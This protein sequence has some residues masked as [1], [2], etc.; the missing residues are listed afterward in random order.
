ML[1]S[2]RSGNTAYGWR[3]LQRCG[4]G[5][6]GACQPEISRCEGQQGRDLDCGNEDERCGH[7]DARPNA[8]AVKAAAPMRQ[9]SAIASHPIGRHVSRG[10]R[11]NAAK[12]SSRR[13]MPDRE[14]R[15]IA[16]PARPMAPT[17]AA[18]G[19]A[20]AQSGITP[21][22]PAAA[23]RHAIETLWNAVMATKIPPPAHS[24]PWPDSSPPNKA[25]RTASPRRAG[26]SEFTNEPT[27]KNAADRRRPGRPPQRH[28]ADRHANAENTSE[29]T[30]KTTAPA[31]GTRC[32]PASTLVARSRFRPGR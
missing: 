26:V 12:T 20:S 30:N 3:S 19:S 29:A 1:S 27:P 25:T 13:K 11:P 5:H 18:A 7:G 14:P 17:V 10:D 23:T 16:Q 31:S 28:T 8:V 21:R 9:Q 24:R 22:A 4:E 32:A 6:C 2:T 15:R